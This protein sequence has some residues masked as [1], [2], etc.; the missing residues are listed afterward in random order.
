MSKQDMASVR[1]Y[2]YLQLLPGSCC[3]PWH[4]KQDACM[5]VGEPSRPYR[6]VIMFVDNAGADILLGMVPL[7]R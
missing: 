3:Y 7:A 5:F 6:R 2:R 4:N 1:M